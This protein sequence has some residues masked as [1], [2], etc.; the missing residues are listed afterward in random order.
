MR[1]LAV[2]DDRKLLNFLVRALREDAYAVD[3]ALGADRAL[4]AA[5][6]IPYDL[7]LLDLRLRGSSGIRVC[8]ELRK[9]RIKAPIMLLAGDSLM[10]ERV[11]GLHAGA[12][13]CLPKPF[14]VPELR[15]R[16]FAL[17]RRSK[18]LNEIT[19]RIAD[20]E[21]DRHRRCINRAGVTI[22]L[23]AKEFALV[24]LLMLHSPDTVTRSEI[25]EHV[26]D[27]QYDSDTNLVDVYIYRLRQKIND[28]GQTRL[29][30]AIR[31]V[32]YK[33]ACAG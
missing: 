12:D 32:G 29:I 23:T 33:L 3:T 4:E 16:V 6:S 15:A 21:I 7:I 19:S 27:C 1:L 18:D 24:E 10:E 8:T 9:Y 20:L 2:G 5:R 26:W 25:I 31:G 11:E 22:P 17:I 28:M 13:D 30:H 14:A